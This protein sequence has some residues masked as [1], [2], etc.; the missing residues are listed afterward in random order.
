MDDGT[1]LILLRPGT[2]IDDA[3]ADA[4][5]EAGHGDLLLSRRQGYPLVIGEFPH[6]ISYH[7]R[8]VIVHA[9]EYELLRRGLPVCGWM[10]SGLNRDGTSPPGLI[11]RAMRAV[12]RLFALR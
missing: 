3:M 1:F 11:G 10:Y 8:D 6:D 9:A 4:V 7:G 5:F 2:E 12:R